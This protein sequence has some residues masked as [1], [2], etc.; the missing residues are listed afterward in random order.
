MD[1]NEKQKAIKNIVR[2]L[3]VTVAILV[4]VLIFFFAKRMFFSPPV[5][6]EV[7]ESIGEES[8][9]LQ[10]LNACGVKGLAARTAEYLKARGFDPVEIGNSDDIRELS[11]VVDR[12]GDMQSARQVAYAV[13]VPDSLISVEVDSNLYV[14]TTVVIGKNYKE[15]KPFH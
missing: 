10:I 8:I 13:G 15:L 2:V 1:R 14:R 11:E 9:R 4:V 5:D 6:S 12:V 7:P 3:N